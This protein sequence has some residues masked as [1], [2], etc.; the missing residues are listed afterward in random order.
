MTIVISI[1]GDLAAAI[2]ALLPFVEPIALA[3]AGACGAG[4][5]TQFGLDLGFRLAQRALRA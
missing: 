5:L 1:P 2:R 3:I 4:V